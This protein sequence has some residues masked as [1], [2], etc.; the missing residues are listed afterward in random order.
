MPNLSFRISEGE[1][2]LIHGPFGDFYLRESNR[3]ILLMLIF[4]VRLLWCNPA[5]TC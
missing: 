5:L 2:L 1:E 4:V 3:D